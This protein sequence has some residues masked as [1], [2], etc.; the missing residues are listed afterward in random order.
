MHDDADVS[1]T[2]LDQ[3][4]EQ[5]PQQQHAT[6]AAGEAQLDRVGS[7]SRDS[8]RDP[9]GVHFPSYVFRFHAELDE[10]SLERAGG[11][12][13]RRRV[14]RE[15]HHRAAR[16]PHGAHFVWG[17]PRSTAEVAGSGQRAVTTLVCV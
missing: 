16:T 17:N 3:L 4:A 13:A 5:A 15:D 14:A 11:L 10:C 12:I 7:L 6:R 9:D 2:D 1:S 8:L